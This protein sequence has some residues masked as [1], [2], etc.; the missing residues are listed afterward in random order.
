MFLAGCS[1]LLSG[2]CQAQGSAHQQRFHQCFREDGSS[3]VKRHSAC[4]KD[5]LSSV[6]ARRRQAMTEQTL[7]LVL[8]SQYLD[9]VA[10]N[11]DFPKKAA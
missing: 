9:V 1:I 3:D 4:E 11:D 7:E 8:L 10:D 2:L 6:L 5:V